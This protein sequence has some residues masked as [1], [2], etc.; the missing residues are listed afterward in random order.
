MDKE[1]LYNEYIKYVCN[2]GFL[3]PKLNLE[4]PLYRYRG[5]PNY[6]TDEI[7]N[8]HIYMASLKDLNDPFDSS[9]AISYKEACELIN[10]IMYFH[11]RCYFLDNNVWY[12][13]LD[14]YIRGL[15]DHLVTL[16]EYAKIVSN[17]VKRQGINISVETICMAYYKKC[18]IK[19]TQRRN[20]GKVSS[21]SETWSSIPMW[22]YYAD[23]HKGVCMKYD[24]TLLDM[25]DINYRNI[26]DSLH[27]VWYSEQR[28][29][30]VE[31]V[32]TP[33]VKSLQWAHEQEWRL[34]GESIEEYIHIPCLTEIYLGINF[35]YSNVDPIIDAIKENGRNIKLFLVHPQP[36]L[37]G[38][39]LVP[40]S[41]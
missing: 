4:M 12:R 22:S 17:F 5:N 3:I 30:D 26:R 32:F 29:S 2:G 16:E 15:E 20:L 24:F 31:G 8:D 38:F 25:N 21:F 39:E 13:E 10:H 23:S 35:D 37:Y 40:L 11:L 33:F 1:S 41:I 34:F 9:V 28:F 18:M 14:E 36:N 7:R 19:P 27:K 6:I